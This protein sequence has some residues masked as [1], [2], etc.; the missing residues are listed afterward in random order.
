MLIFETVLIQNFSCF[1]DMLIFENLRVMLIFEK[2]L[3]IARVRY[4]AKET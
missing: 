4:M 3:I 2:V 1:F